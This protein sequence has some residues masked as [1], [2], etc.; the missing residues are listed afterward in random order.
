MVAR[1]S[2]P[3][4]ALGGGQR[5]GRRPASG[6]WGAERALT[7]SPG[8]GAT[9]VKGVTTRPPR[10][11]VGLGAGAPPGLQATPLVVW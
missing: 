7:L 5:G 10:V 6:H 8:L 3:S 4:A 9:S 1:S 2:Q 11:S